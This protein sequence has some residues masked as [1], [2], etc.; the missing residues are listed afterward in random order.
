MEEKFLETAEALQASLT[1]E[2]LT[3]VRAAA[4]QT[5]PP[6]FSGDCSCGEPVPPGRI[7]LGYYNCVDCQSAKETR[8]R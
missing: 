3:R 8:S 4:Q 1:A 2:A 7:A 5:R 6:D